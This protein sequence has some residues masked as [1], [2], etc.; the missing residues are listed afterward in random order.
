MPKANANWSVCK[1]PGAT[2]SRSLRM[3]PHPPSPLPLQPLLL[4]LLLLMPSWDR[5]FR[6]SAPNHP[7]HQQT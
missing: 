3:P 6:L 5:R 1:T 7:P 4:P 2:R